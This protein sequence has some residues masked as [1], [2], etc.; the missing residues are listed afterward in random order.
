MGRILKMALRSRLP[1]LLSDQA[2]C[3]LARSSHLF[4]ICTVKALILV[5][6]KMEG[7]PYIYEM[8]FS[9]SQALGQ[10]QGALLHPLQ[11]TGTT[12]IGLP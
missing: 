4:P 3:P 9:S 7:Y 12:I 10:S 11:T 5:T 8:T 2:P 6:C 1:P